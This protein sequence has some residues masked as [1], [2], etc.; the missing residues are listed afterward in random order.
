M[1]VASLEVFQTSSQ[2]TNAW[3]KGLMPEPGWEDGL[4]RGFYYEGWDPG[5]KPVREFW[6]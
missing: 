5:G 6:P 4:V 3:L 1:T 2:K